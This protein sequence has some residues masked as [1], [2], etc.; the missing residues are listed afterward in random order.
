MKKTTHFHIIAILIGATLA[1]SSCS[2][3][4]NVLPTQKVESINNTD[5]RVIDGRLVFPDI[6]S[7]QKVRD[8]LWNKNSQ[9]LDAWEKSLNFK[10]LRTKKIT[11]ADTLSLGLMNE[12]GFPMQYATLINQKGEYQIGSN[13]YWFHEGFKYQAA[14]EKELQRIKNNPSIA[15]QKYAAGKGLTSLK[16]IALPSEGT[17]SFQNRTIKGASSNGDGKFQTQFNLSNDANSQRRLSLENYT[18][19]E[20]TS[21]NPVV[22]GSSYIRTIYT[23]IVLNE[24]CE[25][26]S[27]GSK[28]WYRAGDERNTSYDLTTTAT[29]RGSNFAPPSGNLVQPV[30]TKGDPY[31]ANSHIT[32]SNERHANSDFQRGVAGA[33]LYSEGDTYFGG[34][35][36]DFEIKGYYEVYIPSD[37]YRFYQGHI[38]YLNG[39]LW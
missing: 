5:L 25:Y 29:A 4:Q 36:W 30:G 38:L 28:R 17:G 19:A 18:Y 13:I 35:T 10:S 6:E 37:T 2:K 26:Y 15:E 16:H 23:A 39:V 33:T 22:A 9:E 1:L 20:V 14:S 7:F 12:F 11:Q 8:D 27:R 32:T 31:V 24:Y 34:I 21:Y 3:E